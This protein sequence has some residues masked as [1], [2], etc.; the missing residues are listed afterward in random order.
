MRLTMTYSS[1]GDVPEITPTEDARE[2][3]CT[4]N[5]TAS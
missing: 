3:G 5:A 4:T 1:F 2:A